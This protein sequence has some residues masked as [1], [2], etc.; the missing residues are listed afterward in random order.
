MIEVAAGV[1][2]SGNLQ[3]EISNMQ[4][5]LVY[6][7]PPGACSYL[8]DETSRL[9]YELVGE[10]S[11]AEYEARLLAGWRR[12]GF[13]LFRPTCPACRKC[14]SLRVPVATFTPDRSQRR[15]TAANDGEI[16]LRIGTP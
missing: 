2:A 7:P 15:A 6:T 4:S 1:W 12:F 16:A 9:T 5:L 14:L 3:S 13:S 8:P 11:A 10:L